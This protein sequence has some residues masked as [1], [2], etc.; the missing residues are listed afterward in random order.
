MTF[1]VLPWGISGVGGWAYALESQD[2]SE[3]FWSVD[4]TIWQ[5]RPLWN[6][7][8]FPTVSMGKKIP[9]LMWCPRRPSVSL[10]LQLPHRLPCALWPVFDVLCFSFQ[11]LDN[12]PPILSSLSWCKSQNKP[13]FPSV[14]PLPPTASESAALRAPPNAW[15]LL[16]TSSDQQGTKH[17]PTVHRGL[18]LLICY[19]SLTR[20][21]SQAFPV[22]HASV[23]RRG[24]CIVVSEHSFCRWDARLCICA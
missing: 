21:A 13:A 17:P 9:I 14:L 11:R 12:P 20:E 7:Q 10:C 18:L 15:D 1:S 3:P 4:T 8:W 22:L 24:A 6:F 19:F 5:P 16:A 2:R 23:L